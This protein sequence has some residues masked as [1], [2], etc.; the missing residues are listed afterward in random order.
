MNNAVTAQAAVLRNTGGPLQ[1]E[2]IEVGPPA[3]DEVLVRMV[4]VGVCH[5]DIVCRDG[6]G[7][8]PPIVLGHEG[9]GVVEAVGSAVTSLKAG[10]RVVLSFN[11]CGKCAS[12]ADDHPATCVQFLP[13]NFAGVRIA[14]GTTPLSKDG[15]VIKGMFFGQSSFATY[16]IAREVNAV[17]VPDAAPLELLGPLGCG[18][19][20]GAGA[21]INSLAPKKHDS[22]V[23]F[24]GGAV[25]LSALLG[26]LAIGLSN[27]FVVE[28]NPARRKLAKELGAHNVLNPL[29]G[30]NVVETIQ[31]ESG[32]VKFAL[33]T[34]GI[35]AVIG[36]AVACVV[37]GGT[38][39]MVGVPAPEGKFPFT[40]LELLMKGVILRPIT[41]GDANPKTFIPEMIEMYKK[42][43]FPFD[44]LVTR[45]EFAKINEAMH[46]AETGAVI[47]PVLIF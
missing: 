44:K 38:V 47:K 9:S 4:G 31:Q 6:F 13:F 27:I 17:K 37:S 32:G 23:I 2:N 15:E 10:D 45:F 30:S 20:T 22:L 35:P 7:V 41:E 43:I 40:P 8:Q 25:G 42:G 11:S 26:G 12:C 5:T 46:A 29:D 14:D 34:T 1:I 16:A 3:A 39:G 36:Q 19:Q 24:G 18:V 33:D 21:V 28:P